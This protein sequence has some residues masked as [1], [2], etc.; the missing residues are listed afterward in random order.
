MLRVCRGGA[1]ESQ[2]VENHRDDIFDHQDEDINWILVNACF[3]GKTFHRPR[4]T[5]GIV[6]GFVFSLNSLFSIFWRNFQVCSCWKHSDRPPIMGLFLCNKSLCRL[7]AVWFHLFFSSLLLHTIVFV[8][9]APSC[10]RSCSCP[11]TKEVHCTFRHFT[12][13]PKAFP[14]ATE[15]LNLGYNSLTE[16]EGSEFR[17]LRQLEMLMLHGNDISRVHPGA[18]YTLRSLQVLFYCVRV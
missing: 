5:Q 12:T 4:R 14:K 8:H 6:Q 9:G 10:P 15:R 16:V 17:S 18:F 11:G 1:E 2:E 13:I 7:A 3:C